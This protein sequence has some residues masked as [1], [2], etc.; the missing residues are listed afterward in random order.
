M[1]SC[2][3]SLVTLAFLRENL[4]QPQF[5]KDLTSKT[6]FFERWSRFKFHNLGLTLGKI[7]RFYT[8]VAKRFKLKVRNSWGKFLRLK[9]LQGKNW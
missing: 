2:D 1:C 5:Y 8:S 7:L 9:K 6:A 3:Q 4:S